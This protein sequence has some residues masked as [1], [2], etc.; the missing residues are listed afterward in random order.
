MNILEK[1]AKELTSFPP[2]TDA[3]KGQLTQDATDLAMNYGP[4]ALTIKTPMAKSYPKDVNKLFGTI[5]SK[6]SDIN[7]NAVWK[8][9]K[10]W[11][12]PTHI[13]DY[14]KL[15]LGEI[16]D[17]LAKVNP[18]WTDDYYNAHTRGKP[19]KYGDF[20]DHAE[21]F[22]N[23]PQLKDI[24]VN[25]TRK[26]NGIYNPSENLISINPF[27]KGNDLL[28]TALHEGQHAIQNFSMFPQHMRGT[29][30]VAMEKM[31]RKLSKADFEH[32]LTVHKNNIEDQLAKMNAYNKIPGVSRAP[33]SPT[34]ARLYRLQD[35]LVD[36]YRTLAND[37][38]KANPGEV[39]ARMP[40]NR[41]NQTEHPLLTL[42]KMGYAPRT[43][44]RTEY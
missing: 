21:M 20:M 31:L 24:N 29:S 43:W 25:P 44:T 30:N 23:Y 13:K 17:S 41:I 1:L 2:V 38:Y 40:I 19:F 42:Y 28:K 27:L 12:I 14:N 35:E 33:V 11:A 39:L 34:M 6:L 36:P 7:N 4:M 37:L 8:E 32:V 3:T 26:A 5:K 9:H 15:L 22:Y 16:D 10:L 18:N